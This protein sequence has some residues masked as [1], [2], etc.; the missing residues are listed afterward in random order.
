MLKFAV[1]KLKVS[2]HLE[3]CVRR[4]K[5]GFDSLQ[6]RYSS[7]RISVVRK[8]GILTNLW[9]T[10]CFSYQLQGEIELREGVICSI[11]M[12][13]CKSEISFFNGQDSQTFSVSF[14]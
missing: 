6:S 7:L 3:A 14:S 12:Y 1:A 10:E 11:F 9:K 5:G 2:P 13:L 8:V 4:T